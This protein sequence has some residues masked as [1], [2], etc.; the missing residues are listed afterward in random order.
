[1]RGRVPRRRFTLIE[2]L[3][4]IA[5]IAILAAMLLPA[6]AQARAKAQQ[7]SCLS[8]LKQIGLGAIMY[9]G[10]NTDCWPP[11]IWS[12][13]LPAITYS[14]NNANGA[15][16]T[17]QHRP[18]FWH[19][20]NY[21]ND[22]KVLTCP[23]TGSND[24]WNGLGYNRYIGELMSPRTISTTT[25]PTFRIMAGDGTSTW[26]DTYEDFPRMKEPH[27]SGMNLVFCDGHAEWMKKLNFRTQ[28]SRM[29]Q[30][31]TTWHQAGAGYS[32]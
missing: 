19:I 11:N 21:I 10:D 29:H 25:Q 5:I 22:A 16:I 2:L 18:F 14:F 3:V 12:N 26:W 23:T 27:N 8:N 7:I 28:P 9:G 31:N 15:S 17:S 1:M 32:P 24:V 30:N 13:T 4:V 6:L 20:Y